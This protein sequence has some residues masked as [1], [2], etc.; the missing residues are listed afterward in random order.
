[1]SNYESKAQVKEELDTFFSDRRIDIFL[2]ALKDS[3]ELG[4]GLLEATEVVERNPFEM[5]KSLSYS[6]LFNCDKEGV[7]LYIVAAA[8][9]MRKSEKNH[10]LKQG[11]I[12]QNADYMKI[13]V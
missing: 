13:N 10:N 3:K 9:Q 4:V 7:Y 1:L 12:S 11:E 2:T 8:E 5:E 6:N